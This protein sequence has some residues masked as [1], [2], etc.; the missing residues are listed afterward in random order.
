MGGQVL[1]YEEKDILNRGVDQGITQGVDIGQARLE[2]AFLKL[3]SGMTTEDLRDLGF[4][5]NTIMRADNMY[6]KMLASF[7]AR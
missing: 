3:Q 4:D 5:D 6:E 7:E 2:D 1:E